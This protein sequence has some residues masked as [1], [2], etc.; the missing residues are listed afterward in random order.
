MLFRPVQPLLLLALCGCNLFPTRLL[1]GTALDHGLRPAPAQVRQVLP[2]V[3]ETAEGRRCHAVRL[4]DR[5]IATAAH[6]VAGSVRVDL[7]ENGE[8]IQ[9]RDTLLH[10]ARDLASPD[11][12][13]ASDLAKLTVP[14]SVLT[15]ARVR[16]APLAPGQVTILVR[17]GSSNTTAIPCGFLGRSGT[18]AELSCAVSLG[19]SGAPVVQ[20]GALVGILSGRGRVGA[21]DIAQIAVATGLDSF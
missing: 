1:P 5:T 3:I 9:T 21:L 12:A 7:I 11:R 19:W 13:A 4:D 2:E 18:M 10:P 20:D 15:S 14:A 8:R 17:A 6:C 16:I